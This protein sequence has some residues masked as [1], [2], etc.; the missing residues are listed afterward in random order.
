MTTGQL[1]AMLATVR[2]P[3]GLG[4]RFGPCFYHQKP[5]A[6]YEL[7]VYSDI[8]DVNSR[9][10]DATSVGGNDFGWT[11]VEQRKADPAADRFVRIQSASVLRDHDLERMDAAQF[12]AWLYQRLESALRHELDEWFTIGGKHFREPHPEPAIG[13]G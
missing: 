4:I 5:G 11:V 12:T 10:P 9:A 13:A 2:L 1:R 3:P 8:V 7:V 6:W